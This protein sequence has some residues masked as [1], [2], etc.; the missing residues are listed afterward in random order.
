MYSPNDGLKARV[1]AVDEVYRRIYDTFNKRHFNVF[2]K[3]FMISFGEYEKRVKSAISEYL[4]Q[5]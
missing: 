4:K 2:V 5:R 3:V 1:I